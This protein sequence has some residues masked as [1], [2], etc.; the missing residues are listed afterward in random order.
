[1]LPQPWVSS[2]SAA[3]QQTHPP[4]VKLHEG[5]VS[6]SK[7]KGSERGVLEWYIR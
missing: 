5:I 4:K 1:M 6:I 3:N 7:K 2:I